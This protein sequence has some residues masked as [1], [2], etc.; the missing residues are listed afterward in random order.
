M[1]KRKTIGSANIILTATATQFHRAL[2]DARRAIRGFAI[3]AAKT[4]LTL[5]GLL[6]GATVVLGVRRFVDS[7]KEAFAELE[8][9]K[10]TAD[11]LQ[12]ST[13]ALQ[14]FRLAADLAGMST[15]T[16]DKALSKMLKSIGDMAAGSAESRKKLNDFGIVLED[17][18]AMNT[19][20]QLLHV[21]D[22]FA[23]LNSATERAT[24]ASTLFGREW[25]EISE[26]LDMGSD[27]LRDAISFMKSIGS[28]NR[29]QVTMIEQANVSFRR[30]A[31]IIKN[32]RDLVAVQLS[33][34]ISALGDALTKTGK[35]AGN[36][37]D[38]IAKA[39]EGVVRS[40]AK[41]VEFM[42]RLTPKALAPQAL[43]VVADFKESFMLGNEVFFN[44]L[45]WKKAADAAHKARIQAR[46]DFGAMS[47]E[48]S[49]QVI[50]EDEIMESF[51]RI[52]EQAEENAKEIQQIRPF[53]QDLEDVEKIKEELKG[54]F[55]FRTAGELGF[56]DTE[57][58]PFRQM[59]NI[60]KHSASTGGIVGKLS[61]L[62][63]E[64]RTQTRI[65]LRLQNA[66]GLA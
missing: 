10:D 58:P 49:E 18:L 63:D 59:S 23:K 33:P 20:E 6:S 60:G 15:Q 38:A 8:Q 12:I 29:T 26:V 16:F 65:L 53:K 57:I 27:Q 34:F 61:A 39:F 56:R 2:K 50:S 9:L 62:I 31:A 54:S 3:G 42:S 30:F 1:A 35:Q 55:G 45:G 28:P 44:W 11:A 40:F 48:L 25:A 22:R 66:G 7:M 4:F 51:K 13:E 43:G 17:L 37:G 52:R 14:G 64:T 36:M 41:T 21:I 46:D 32:V 19:E 24:F 47:K 5:G